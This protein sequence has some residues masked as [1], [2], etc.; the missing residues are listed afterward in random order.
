MISKG[1][2]YNMKH[3]KTVFNYLHCFTGQHKPFGIPVCQS[4]YH[5][6]ES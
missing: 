4:D 1:E 5:T 2:G 3:L 6:V